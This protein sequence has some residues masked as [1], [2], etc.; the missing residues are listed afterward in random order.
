MNKPKRRPGTPHDRIAKKYLRFK[1]IVADLLEFYTD[2]VVAEYVDIDALQP[3][4]TH[5]I[6]DEL[7][8]VI[9]DVSFVAR[10]RDV[11]ARSEVLFALEHK[12]SP[13]R[14]VALQVGT[15]AFLALYT[16][17]TDAE[18]SEAKDFEL[19]IPIMIVLY[20]GVDDWATKEIQFQDLF[21]N[22]PA[23]FRDLV[24]RFKVLV[25]NL[26]KFQYG[27]LPGRPI[28]RAF[29][30]SLMRATDGTI[31][32]HLDSIFRHI[33]EADLE[34]S[35]RWDFIQTI[36]S[37]GSR[38]VGL[39]R[40]QLQQAILKI[41][42]GKEGIEMAETIPD[43]LLKDGIEIGEARGRLDEKRNDILTLLQLRFAP[44]PSTIFE[45]LSKM[46]DLTAMQSLFVL[47][48][49]CDTLDEFGEALK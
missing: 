14:M 40:A 13:S 23:A 19:P 31:G 34:R 11:A 18:Y 28:T 1:V 42:E 8:E 47:A 10:L 22:V 21:R 15:Q 49:Q 26:R 36:A 16:A 4:P 46:T 24:P 32:T 35:L 41:F 39:T 6:S 20:H 17:W 29:V 33:R 27:N 45:E 7:K 48:A 38:I 3:A 30:E 9:M 44:I 12:S 37:Y 43:G 2:P 25:I 5:G